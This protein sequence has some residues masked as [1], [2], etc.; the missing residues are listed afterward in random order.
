M[1]QSKW[2][3]NL[4]WRD[5]PRSN[6]GRPCSE[7]AESFVGVSHRSRSRVRG[8]RGG[9]VVL[10]VEAMTCEVPFAERAMIG[11]W[12][13]GCCCV[14]DSTGQPMLLRSNWEPIIMIQISGSP[15]FV[16]S[17]SIGSSEQVWQQETPIKCAAVSSSSRSV[18]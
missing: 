4:T 13:A 18:M 12:K 16:C 6:F 9:R 7:S 2:R 3:H 14:H 17:C 5:E 1:D 8:M 10:M 11:P 15:E